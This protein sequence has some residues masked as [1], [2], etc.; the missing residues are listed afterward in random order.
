MPYRS[1]G[2]AKTPAHSASAAA[3]AGSSTGGTSARALLASGGVNV[4]WVTRRLPHLR[5]GVRPA[6]EI[7]LWSRLL[8]WAAAALALAWF[9]SRHSGGYGTGLWVRWDSGW[10]LGIARHGYGSDTVNAPAFFPLYPGMTA[11]LG[12]ILAGRYALAALLI[13]LG[14]CLAAFE[15]L[16][17]LAAKRLGPE[18]AF[19]SV[20]YL[21][22]F[23]TALFLQAVYSESLYLALALA[24]FALAEA[25]RWPWAAA[26]AGLALLTRSSGVAVVAGIAVLAWPQLKALLWIGCTSVALFALF[27][28]TLLLQ[29]GNAW[30][31]L[32][33]EAEWDRKLSDA[34]PFGGIWD[35]FARLGSASKGAT[36]H[37]TLAV[38]LESLGFL[39][40]FVALLA[41]VW[42]RFG[43]AYGVFATV[44]LLFPLSFPA[45]AYPLLSLPRFGLVVFPF[46]LVL[47][48]FGS[49][50][51]VHA[52]IL[53]VSALL[54][55]VAIVEWATFNWVA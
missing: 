31:F 47:A 4:R 42:R 48:G 12:R 51:R 45:G 46:F 14:S 50:P 29:A 40:L 36:F 27:P 41:E 7:F 8:I 53:S 49:R 33:S 34:G 10:F 43:P 13:T 30:A 26:A 9:P 20:L 17:H 5:G 22:L 28:L 25:R 19:R 6:A 32:H 2:R 38:N 44:S 21:A 37:H 35:A 15:L 18:G 23:P 24:A 54:L 16:W 3:S 52:A 39:F 55:G 11:V 1:K